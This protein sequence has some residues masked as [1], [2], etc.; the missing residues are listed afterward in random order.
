MT[1]RVFQLILTLPPSPWWCKQDKMNHFVEVKSSRF[2]LK[3]SGSF[4]S[5]AFWSCE[6][7]IR[8]WPFSQKKKKTFFIVIVSSSLFTL[9]MMCCITPKSNYLRGE[10]QQYSIHHQLN[11][12][13][14]NMKKLGWT[15]TPTNA[16]TIRHRNREIKIWKRPSSAKRPTEDGGR[17]TVTS[18]TLLQEHS[19]TTAAA[20]SLSHLL[21]P[22]TKNTWPDSS[23]RCRTL[24][25]TSLH[26]CLDKCQRDSNVVCC[27]HFNTA[28]LLQ[29]SKLPF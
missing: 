10:W 4:Q 17:G 7:E 16:S 25:T 18:G 29:C 6:V 15:F 28:I 26:A 14:K 9:Q 24:L 22:P 8:N 23:P 13:D 2:R 1:G 20:Q 27:C 5:E 3:P 19:H 11:T 21:N 12:Y